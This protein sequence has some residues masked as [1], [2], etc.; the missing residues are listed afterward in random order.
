LDV[1]VFYS[2]GITEKC[3][4]FINLP[5]IYM[6]HNIKKILKIKRKKPIYGEIIIKAYYLK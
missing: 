2:F 4:I 1:V 3:N 5:A 6:S